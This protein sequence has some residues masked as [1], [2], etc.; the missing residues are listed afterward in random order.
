MANLSTNVFD[1]NF[2]R[3]SPPP[4]YRAQVLGIL[5]HIVQVSTLKAV[6]EAAYAIDQ[7][8]PPLEYDDEADAALH[9]Q[10]IFILVHVQAQ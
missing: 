10:L 6:A 4:D 1:L 8:C 7:L 9:L 2:T 5:S 3:R